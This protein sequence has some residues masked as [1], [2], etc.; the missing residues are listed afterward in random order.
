ML[1]SNLKSMGF[2]V[3]K[4]YFIHNFLLPIPSQNHNQNVFYFLVP[5]ISTN[6]YTPGDNS[7]SKNLFSI[8][9]EGK[10]ME[11]IVGHY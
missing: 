8:P 6:S 7:I 10:F 1:S 3:V 9:N 2:E 11:F 4:T 5:F